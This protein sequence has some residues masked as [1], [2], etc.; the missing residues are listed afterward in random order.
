MFTEAADLIRNK[1]AASAGNEV[2]T[3]TIS[4]LNNNQF[5]NSSLKGEPYIIVFSATWCGPCQLQLP[6]LKSLY[7]AYKG[8]GLKVIYFNDDND[9][10]RW[11]EHVSKNEL[12]W[13]N[14]SE[15]LKPSI[16][17]IPKS[18]GVYSIPTCLVINKQGTIIYNS[19]Q[20][21]P[22][23]KEIESYIK[24]VIYN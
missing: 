10:T 2:K 3:F 24:E 1:I 12:T 14:V 11:K 6:K 7:D 13:I 5:T 21:D 19:D 8:K 20:N 17:K 18:F 16:S 22:G 9:V 23:I 15:K 4:D